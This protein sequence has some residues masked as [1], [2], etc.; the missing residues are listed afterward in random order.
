MPAPSEW[1]Y[2]NNAR[3]AMAFLGLAML[4]LVLGVLAV[5]ALG[6]EAAIVG[7]ALLT[8]AIFLLVFSLL[9]FVPRLAVRG[10][11]SFSFYSRRSMDD[12]ERAVRGALEALGRT[13]RVETVRT[14]SRTPP[15]VVSAE[16][17][18]ARVRIELSRRPVPAESGEWTEIIEVVSAREEPEGQALRGKIIEGL[19]IEGTCG[20]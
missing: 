3:I 2:A 19:A 10:A 6:L 4:L 16:G 5:A 1:E 17:F 9:V 15:R 18:P 20:P 13:P 12:A 7:S 8:I 11:V 14:R